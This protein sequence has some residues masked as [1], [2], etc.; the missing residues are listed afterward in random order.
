MSMEFLDDC[1]EDDRVC[2]GGEGEVFYE[3]G[4]EEFGGER[5]GEI[6]FYSVDEVDCSNLDVELS[7]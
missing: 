1:V 5:R 6:P 2:C 7:Q 4:G 3:D